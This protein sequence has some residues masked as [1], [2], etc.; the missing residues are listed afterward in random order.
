MG[1]VG[2]SPVFQVSRATGDVPVE[3]DAIAA[4]AALDAAGIELDVIEVPRGSLPRSAGKAVR[5]V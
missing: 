5:V 4:Q 2:V 1:V 3:G